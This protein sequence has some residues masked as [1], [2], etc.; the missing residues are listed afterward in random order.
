MDHKEK[1]WNDPKDQHSVLSSIEGSIHEQPEK[2]GWLRKLLDWI[3]KGAAE[4]KID[5]TGCPT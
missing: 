5:T 4:S 3:S 1:K 2:I